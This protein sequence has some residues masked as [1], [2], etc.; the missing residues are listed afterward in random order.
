M[1]KFITENKNRPKII[2]CTYT[3]MLAIRREIG[4]ITKLE[5]VS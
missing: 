4:K 3:A 1:K 5:A 2:Y